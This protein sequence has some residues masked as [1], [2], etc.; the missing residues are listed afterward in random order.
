[1]A[2]WR[3]LPGSRSA[4]RVESVALRLICERE[5]EIE[6][7]APPGV[8]DHRRR[9]HDR[10]RQLRSGPDAA[11]AAALFERVGVTSAF[12]ACRQ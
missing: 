1:M 3:K 8:V 12:D 5:A 7:F 2:L 4:G 6:A 10:C 9:R 11:E